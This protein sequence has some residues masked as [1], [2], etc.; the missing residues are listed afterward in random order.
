MSDIINSEKNI[1]LEVNSDAD[2]TTICKI[3]RALSVPDRIRILRSLLLRSKNV[4]DIAAELN[5]PVSSVARHIDVLADAQL[6]FVDYQPGLKGHTKYCS[7]IVMSY[8]VDLSSPRIEESPEREYSVEIPVGMFSECDIKAPCG[9]TG[10]TGSLGAFDDP[11]IFFEPTRTDAECIWFDT[12]FISYNFPT[13]PLKHHRCTEISF[14]FEACS[15]TV[16]YNNNWP[17]DITVSVNGVEVTTFTSP[18]DFGGRRGKFTPEYWPITSTQFGLLKKITVNGQGVFVDNAMVS[19]KVTFDDLKLY[20][21]SA[22]ILSIGVREDAK[23]RG[24]INLFGKNFGDFPQ[25]I[26]MSVK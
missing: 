18:G 22:V 21:G 11:G 14:S 23:H 10:K 12:G 5:I 6:I 2:L 4:S 1:R 17:S 15:E 3:S 25:A 9:M 24:G 19:S 8:M 13:S 7:Q 20:E 26:V 16:Y